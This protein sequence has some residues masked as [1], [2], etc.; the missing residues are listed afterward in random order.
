MSIVIGEL[1]MINSLYKRGLSMGNIFRKYLDII[2]D[3]SESVSIFEGREE[4]EIA[5]IQAGRYGTK[6]LLQFKANIESRPGLENLKRA[7]ELRLRTSDPR[8]SNRAYGNEREKAASEMEDLNKKLGDII[9]QGTNV[10]GSGVKT[11]GDEI[12]GE[13]YIHKYLSYKNRDNLKAQLSV[14]QDTVESEM[15]WRTELM[16]LD[17]SDRNRI[18]HVDVKTFAY[19]E[20]AQAFNSYVSNLKEVIGKR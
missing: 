8:A 17:S 20:K 11:G 19:S 10:I 14:I 16:I 7:I 12:R 15:F 4:D 9:P 18:N 5:K 6:E 13:R 3:L 1:K 2:Q